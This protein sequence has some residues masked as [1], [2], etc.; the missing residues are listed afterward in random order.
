MLAWC[1]PVWCVV[2]VP[3]VARTDCRLLSCSH[4]LT[5]GRKESEAAA[6]FVSALSVNIVS[7]LPSLSHLTGRMLPATLLSCRHSPALTGKSQY[8]IGNANI[9]V[10]Y[11][12]AAS[13]PMIL[14]YE[15]MF[16]IRQK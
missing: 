10:K 16:I 15:Q 14:Y 4:L 6:S 11:S 5:A 13:A 8:E 2:R 9:P 3:C 1:S 12:Q 7:D